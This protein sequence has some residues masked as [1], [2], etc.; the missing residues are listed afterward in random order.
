MRKRGSLPGRGETTTATHIDGTGS[1][2]WSNHSACCGFTICP[3]P[4]NRCLYRSEKR[5]DLDWFSEDAPSGGI[6]RPFA[7]RSF[8][9]YWARLLKYSLLEEERQDEVSKLLSGTPKPLSY[10]LPSSVL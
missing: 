3:L 2:G 1:F 7:I 5:G 4:P 10:P 6:C 8:R 9:L